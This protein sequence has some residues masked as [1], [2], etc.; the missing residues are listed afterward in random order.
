MI[1]NTIQFLGGASAVGLAIWYGVS[2]PQPDTAATLGAMIGATIR[3]VFGFWPW[4]AADQVRVLLALPVLV[5]LVQ[6]LLTLPLRG[7][8]S[9]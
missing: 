1:R 9:A 4:V 5:W 6:D 2:A 7:G 3:T 8:A